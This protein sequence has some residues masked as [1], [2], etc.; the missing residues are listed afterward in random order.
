MSATFEMELT[1]EALERSAQGLRKYRSLINRI[2]GSTPEEIRETLMAMEG[3]TPAQIRVA[4]DI[5]KK[6]HEAEIATST[7]PSMEAED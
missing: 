4:C 5:Y 1:A 2:L 6:I 7:V 3:L